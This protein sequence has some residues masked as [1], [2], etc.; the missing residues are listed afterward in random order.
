MV[1]GGDNKHNNWL[2]GGERGIVNNEW[3][4]GGE[5]V[6]RLTLCMVRRDD[7]V[8][9][10]Y[11]KDPK[12]LGGGFW[13]GFG[14]K[15][16]EGETYLQAAA[17]ELEEE[18]LIHGGDIELAG[19]LEFRHQ[20]E[21]NVV[22]QMPVYEV[23]NAVGEPDE[24]EEMCPEWFEINKLPLEKMWQSDAY[25]L[26]LFFE[27]KGFYGQFLYDNKHERNLIE[28]PM[29]EELERI[30]EMTAETMIAEIKSEVRAR[31]GSG[32][33]VKAEVMA[34]AGGGEVPQEVSGGEIRLR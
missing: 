23:T 26:D 6:I 22:R 11:K 15:V 2:A 29:I 7:K 17:R 3:N 28:K 25:W 12:G 10:G 31:E 13:N 1:N 19:V 16:N 30:A 20:D 33:E 14:G 18:C 9:L 34:E 4:D 24:T 5:Q 8:L 27:G 32:V 21:P